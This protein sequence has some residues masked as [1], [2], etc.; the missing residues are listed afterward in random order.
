MIKSVVIVGG[1]TA[2][3]MT[4]TYLQGRLR[5]PGRRD[6]RGIGRA[7]RRSASARPPSAPSATS[8]TIS[9]WTSGT[10]CR[11]ARARTSW[12]SGSRTGASPATTSTTRSSAC[13]WPTGSTWPTGGF[14]RATAAGRSTVDCFVTPCLCEAERS[15]RTLDGSLFAASLDGSLGRSTLDEQR[16]QFPYAYHFDAALLA[17]FLT[18]LRRGPRRRARR[19]TTWS[20]SARTSA[21]GSATSTTQGRQGGRRPVRGLHGVP[22]ATDQ[23]DAGGAVRLLRGRAA[24]QPRRRAAGAARH[25]TGRDRARTRP[26]TAWTPG[27]IWTIPLYGRDGNGYVYS[28]EFCTPEEAERTLREHVGPAADDLEANHIRMRIGR[29]R[30]SWVQQLRGHRPVQRLRRAA[31]VDRDLLH[32]ARASSSWSSTSRTAD[33]RPGAAPTPTTA[34]SRTSWTGSRVPGRCTT[35]RGTQ[36]HAVLEGGQGPRAARGAGRAVAAGLVGAA[37]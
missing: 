36:R 37:R 25:R 3:W 26:R 4:A 10:G 28:D 2:G 29:N 24:Q 31:G 23:Q 35:G 19:A 33:W 34:A 15:P 9:G 1:G 14:R 20:R 12:A 18:G 6:A 27:W 11:R 30:N 21:A 8:S 13:G 32:P 5:R 17:A 22:R 7:S 16:A